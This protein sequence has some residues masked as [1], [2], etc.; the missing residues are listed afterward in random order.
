MQHEEDFMGN[1]Q[2]FIDHEFVC[3]L[4][5]KSFYCWYYP[6]QTKIWESYE[7]STHT[8]TFQMAPG[9]EK[10]FILEYIGY[11]E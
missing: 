4:H 9:D 8:I 1:L 11:I 10:K 6:I 5:R 3:N 7:N 2:V